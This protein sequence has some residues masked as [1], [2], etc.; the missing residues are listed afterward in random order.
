MVVF[1]EAAKLKVC[2]ISSLFSE[3]KVNF[4]V[5]CASL[6]QL[7][8]LSIWKRFKFYSMMH[9]SITISCKTAQIVGAKTYSS[10][11]KSFQA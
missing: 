10:I 3:T 2:I 8:R 9:V 7:P 4:F 1:T 6:I 5:N 11:I